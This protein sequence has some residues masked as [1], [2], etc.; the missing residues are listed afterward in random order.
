MNYQLPFQ[1]GQ[2]LLQLGNSDKPLLRPQIG[3]KVLPTVDI[4]SD[5]RQLLPLKDESWDGI[6]ID[7]EE[8]EPT[9]V[10]RVLK[11]GGYLV[12]VSP[13]DPTST[14]REVGFRDV[15]VLPWANNTLIC[16]ARK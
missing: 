9:G 16:E 4:V 2:R 5:F 6:F 13:Y 1:R 3:S 11:V 15:T 12:V 14:L 10:L 8:I 7:Q